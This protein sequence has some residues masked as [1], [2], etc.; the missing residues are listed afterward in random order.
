MDLAAKFGDRFSHHHFT[1]MPKKIVTKHSD[2]QML[3]L[4]F[5]WKLL[6]YLLPS[7]NL[8]VKTGRVLGPSIA[9]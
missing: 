5:Y 6:E 8:K 9:E 2:G 3:K 7:I 4:S 1:S